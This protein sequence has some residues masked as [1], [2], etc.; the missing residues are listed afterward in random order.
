MLSVA[1]SLSRMLALVFNNKKKEK[2]VPFIA[3]RQKSSMTAGR[4]AIQLFFEVYFFHAMG[5]K[6]QKIGAS[7]EHFFDLISLQIENM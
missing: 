6:V 5:A 2:V 3:W 7:K 4:K 1:Y